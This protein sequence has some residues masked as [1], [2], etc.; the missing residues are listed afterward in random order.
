MM[1]LRGLVAGWRL[2]ILLLG[3]A[4]LMHHA[5]PVGALEF[6]MLFQTKCVMEEINRNT[7]VVGEFASYHKDNSAQMVPM[8]IKVEDP[9]GSVLYEQKGLSTG[10]FAFTTKEDGD[11]KAC[12]TAKDITTAQN[13]KIKLDWKTG[14]AAT[15]WDAVAKKDHLSEMQTELKRLEGTIREIHA[16][17]ISMRSREEEM[18]NINEATNARVAWFSIGSL[19]M[20]ISLAAWQLI[21]LRSFFRKKKLL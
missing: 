14:V 16:E 19:A 4:T 7:L 9:S 8:D 11:F 3:L 12:F 5:W 21:Y 6:D 1:R 18:R 17:M 2:C 10:S 13:S 15:D 20:C